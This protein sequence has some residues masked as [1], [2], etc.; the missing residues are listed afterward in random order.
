M[1][2]CRLNACTEVSILVQ[3]DPVYQILCQLISEGLD[4]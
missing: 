3:S 4:E 2:R 1:L